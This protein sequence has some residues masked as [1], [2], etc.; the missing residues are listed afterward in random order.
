MSCK[1]DLEETQSRKEDH[2][3]VSKKTQVRIEGDPKETQ[4]S[5]KGGE[6]LSYHSIFATFYCV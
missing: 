5:L 6:K 4:M 1:G 2:E 3:N